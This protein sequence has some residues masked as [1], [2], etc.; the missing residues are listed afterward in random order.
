MVVEHP[1][2][3][4]ALVNPRG[5]AHDLRVA[6]ER[7]G[8]AVSTPP[9]RAPCRWTRPH[10]PPLPRAHVHPVV[11]PAVIVVRAV[12]E[13]AEGRAH[14]PR[15][16]R[17]GPSAA[18]PPRRSA[19]GRSRSRRCSPRS[20]RSRWRWA[21]RRSCAVAY[22]PRVR[23]AGS[24]KYCKARRE[25]SS[26]RARPRASGVATAR[27]CVLS[28]KHA[29]LRLRAERGDAGGDE[30]VR[31]ERSIVFVRRRRTDYNISFVT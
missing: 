26:R 9:R 10:S 27:R 4:N 5:E 22:E 19:V 28:L 25:R 3:V 2:E 15:L 8:A 11:E 20:C 18:R 6:A 21:S 14:A 30:R 23:S 24:R 1:S 17:A 31:V 16:R 29:A 12:G 7:T 13:E